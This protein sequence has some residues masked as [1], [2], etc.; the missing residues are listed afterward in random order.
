MKK[1]SRFLACAAVALFM[2][3]CGNP[4]DNAAKAIDK[5]DFV[6]AAKSLSKL[7]V[8]EINEMDAYEQSEVMGL[9]LAIGLSGNEEA[10]DIIDK[11]L[12]LEKVEKKQVKG[13][14]DVVEGVNGLLD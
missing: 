1:I 5:G 12:D 14:L 7:S 13:L 3:S 11:N 4:V 9:A 8:E 2:V 6:E 10:I